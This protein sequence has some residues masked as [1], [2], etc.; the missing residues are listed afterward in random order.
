MTI[1]EQHLRDYYTLLTQGKADE[2]L[3][4]FAGEPAIDTP[5]QGKVMG[6]AAFEQFVHEQQTWLQQYQ[7]RPELFAVTSTTERIG[8]EFICYLQQADETID[9]PVAVVADLNGDKVSAIRVYHSTWPLTGKHIVRA[10]LLTPA[11]HLDE[12]EVITRYMQG[13]GKPDIQLMKT[14]FAPDG[15]VREPSGARY[16]HT[17]A[18][19]WTF[20]S[21]VQEAQG[22]TLKHCTATFDGKQ[23][24]VEYI[25]DNW[26]PTPIPAQAGIAFYELADEQHLHG[27][28]I[29][30]DVTPP[31]Q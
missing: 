18:E 3:A 15:Y 8:V 5:L 2:L 6:R 1:P 7:A 26:G 16:K 25:C 14:V 29:Y 10:P 27:V 9:L 30:D 17:G 12:P 4:M 20:Y 24:F 13:I 11:Q 21:Q 22:V 31:G 23:F 28:R 19:L